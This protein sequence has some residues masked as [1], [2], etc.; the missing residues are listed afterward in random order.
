MVNQHKAS[1]KTI[2]E[3]MWLIENMF[4]PAFIF[5][6]KIIDT[7]TNTTTFDKICIVIT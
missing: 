4:L 6:A 1:N 3:I 2:A 7:K 5:T